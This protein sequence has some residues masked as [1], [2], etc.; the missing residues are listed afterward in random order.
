MVCLFTITVPSGVRSIT[1]DSVTQTSLNIKWEVPENPNG[2]IDHYSVV[3][4]VSFCS[5]EI[6]IQ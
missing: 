4:E 3:Y 2:R 1:V 6:L 5:A